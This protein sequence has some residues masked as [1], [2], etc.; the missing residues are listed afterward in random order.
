MVELPSVGSGMFKSG[1]KAE[2]RFPQTTSDGWCGDYKPSDA[3][4]QEARDERDRFIN[5]HL[6]PIFGPI[7]SDSKPPKTP[8]A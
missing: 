1:G 7:L 8:N 3:A 2:T 6:G 5:Q 4:I